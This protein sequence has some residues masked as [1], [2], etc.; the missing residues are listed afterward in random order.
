MRQ[1][2]NAFY[3]N[4]HNQIIEIVKKECERRCVQRMYGQSNFDQYLQINHQ[5]VAINRVK[6]MEEELK[7]LTELRMKEESANDMTG[8]IRRL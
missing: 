7:E 1:P 4:V 6:V 2:C 5:A 8:S 3:A